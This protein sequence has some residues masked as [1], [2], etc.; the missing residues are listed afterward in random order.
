MRS[1]IIL[2]MIIA[3]S[4]CATTYSCKTKSAGKC[5]SI[6]EVY[7]NVNKDDSDQEEK[8]EKEK[9][10]EWMRERRLKG[11]IE[12]N[13]ILREPKVLRVLL[14]HFEDEEKDLNLGGYVF[15]KIRD[16]EWE[17]Q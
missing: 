7:D 8:D 14:S 13:A 3:M 5:Q 15:V 12:G 6:S 9:N 17:I 11:P 16:S 2:V 1:F 4:G 10:R